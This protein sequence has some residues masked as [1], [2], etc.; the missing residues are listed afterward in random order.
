MSF[1]SGTFTLVAGNP[2][3]TGT[4]I[5]STWANNTLSDIATG[6][7]TCVLKDGTQTITANLPMSAFKLT[8]LGAGSTNGDSVRYEQLFTTAT[9]SLSLTGGLFVAATVSTSGAINMVQ[10]ATLTATSTVAIGAMTGNY[11]FVTGTATVSGFD[12]IRAGALRVIEWTGATPLS[13]SASFILPG[14]ANLTTA[15]GDLSI[16]M[17]D[18]AGTWRTMHHKR[19][20][21]P[22][23]MSPITNSLTGDVALNNTGTYF[24]GPSVAQGTAGTWFVSG[25]VVVRDT[26]GAATMTGKLWDGTTIIAS[27]LLTT[28]A[29]N[30][31]SIISLSGFISAPAGN[32]RISVNDSSST[33]G[34][35]R[36][37]FSGLGNTDSTITAIRI[38]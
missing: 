37:N 26:A 20:G 29:I 13:N 24:D 34:A 27:G 16:A 25:Q 35:I 32:L 33:S 8:G 9:G 19:S 21:A 36:A 17:S 23:S 18:G 11:A 15:T 7:S 5:S 30:T 31:S 12:T 38:A 22:V 4:T 3:T 1:S 2:V 6:L 28:P 14:A 10:A